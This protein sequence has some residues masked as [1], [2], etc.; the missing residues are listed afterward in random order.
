MLAAAKDEVL[1]PPA[2][3]STLVG[4]I[5]EPFVDSAGKRDHRVISMRA[6]DA[7]DASGLEAPVHLAEMECQVWQVLHNMVRVDAIDTAIPEWERMA[8][9]CPDVR[10]ARYQV[11]VD[12]YPMLKIVA[13][14]WPK[15]RPDD[16]ILSV[17]T[18]SA[19]TPCV[20]AHHRRKDRV[21]SLFRPTGNHRT[22]N[23]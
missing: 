21:V 5:I 14:P 2:E 11:G 18:Q 6:G 20:R 16:T 15:V 10:A 8:K 19:M 1:E 12:I 4:P 23:L 13:L 3:A 7:N 17:S 9:I 22:A